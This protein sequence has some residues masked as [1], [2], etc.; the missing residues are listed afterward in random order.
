MI[1]DNAS[2]D[3]TAEIGRAYQNKDARIRYFRSEQNQG[4]A[5][6]FNRA[7]ELS[8]APLFK[9]A[10]CDD[11]HEPRFL[12][13]CVGGLANKPRV[14]LSHTYVK[15]IDESGRAL[16]Y[17]HHGD[18]FV[19]SAGKPVPRPDRDHIAEAAEP[20]VRFGDV[21]THIWWCDQSF[22]VMRR[23][24]FL[25]TSRHGNYW[26]ADKVMLAELALQGPFHQISERLF[27]RRVHDGCSFGK[28]LDELEEH[29]DI[30]PPAKSYHVM[31]LKNYLKIIAS[32]DISLRQR[33]H[34]LASVARQMLQAKPWRQ[35]LHGLVV[36]RF[37]HYVGLLLHRR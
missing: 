37:D 2:T 22:G 35:M 9:W 36:R 6:N 15:M 25:K 21:L 16:R 10:A 32:A 24:A 28:E 7:F 20:E 17:D 3:N 18:C 11:L 34:C 1:S 14:V 27:A 26:G 8:S 29:I 23:N 33:L 5:W 19:D 4:A 30:N 13:C 31:I 12:E